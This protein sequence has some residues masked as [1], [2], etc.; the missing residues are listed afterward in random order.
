MVPGIVFMRG[1]AVAVLVILECEGVEYTILTRQARVPIG[2]SDLPEIPAGMLDYS[3]YLRGV[4][5]DELKEECGIELGPTD[6]ISLTTLAFG[7]QGWRG[8]YPSAGKHYSFTHSFTAV[9]I[10]RCFA[11]QLTTSSA[12]PLLHRPKWGGVCVCVCVWGGYRL[13]G[14]IDILAHARWV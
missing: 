10:G 3:Q 2:T 11:R 13:Q 1:G 14:S 12:V 7:A 6:L 4:A 5:A 8:I 9:A